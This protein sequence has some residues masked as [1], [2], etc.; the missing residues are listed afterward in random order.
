MIPARMVTQVEEELGEAQDEDGDG[1]WVWALVWGD[2][3]SGE[4]WD[5]QAEL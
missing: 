5:C 3:G 2:P 1:L 4:R